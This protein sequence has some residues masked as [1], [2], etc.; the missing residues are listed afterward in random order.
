MA[1]DLKK[2]DIEVI[3]DDEDYIYSCLMINEKRL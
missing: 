2:Q 1:A 3:A